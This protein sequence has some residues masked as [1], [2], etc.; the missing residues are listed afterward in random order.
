LTGTRSQCHIAE[1]T[2]AEEAEEAEDMGEATA[3]GKYSF[4]I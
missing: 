3:E 1:V 4:S 2:E